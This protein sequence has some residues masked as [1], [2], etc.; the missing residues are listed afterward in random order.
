MHVAAAALVE[1]TLAPSAP[2]VLHL[3]HPHP[4]SWSSII[5]VVAR[6]LRVPLVSYPE[7]LQAL[8]DSLKDQSKSEVDHMRANPAL[9][10]LSFFKS[11]QGGDA[12]AGREAMNL[13]LMDTT[14]TQGLVPLLR[15][16]PPLCEAD[17]MGWMAFWKKMGDL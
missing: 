13:P 10:L 17:V 3:A 8:E 6:E 15:E 14:R 4:V 1:I 11:I 12:L 7:W 5:T 9:R 2:G 16:L